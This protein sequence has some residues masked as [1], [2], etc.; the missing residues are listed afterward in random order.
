MGTLDLFQ[1]KFK[2]F[3]A[4]IDFCNARLDIIMREEKQEMENVE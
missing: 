2:E 4:D 1:D 3:E